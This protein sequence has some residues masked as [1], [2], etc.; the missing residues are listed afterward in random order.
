MASKGIPTR[1]TA[2]RINKLP[3]VIVSLVLTLIVVTCFWVVTK[4]QNRL[5]KNVATAPV[6]ETAPINADTQTPEFLQA[7]YLKNLDEFPIYL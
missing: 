7:A 4:R 3:L 1:P 6:I 5:Q 2:K